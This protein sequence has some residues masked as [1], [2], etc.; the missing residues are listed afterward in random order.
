MIFFDTNVQ[1]LKFKVLKEVADLAFED[2]LADG[3]LDIP[4][5]IIPGP[6][7]TMRC[8]IYKERAV[9]AE[10]VKLAMGTGHTDDPVISV[11]PIACDEC[12]VTQISVSESC[13]G[14]IAHRCMNT[15]PRQAI[16]IKNH[17]AHIDQ[18]LC[19][20]CGKCVD[21]CPYGAIVKNLRPCERACKAGAISMDERKKA[22][23]NYDKCVSCGACV[24]QCPF[25]A[26]M[27]RS[28][29]LNAI[30]ILKESDG[31]RCY[32]V[33]AAVAPSISG[34]FG[35][36]VGQVVSGL[37]QLGFY[38][39]V[40]AAL[41][42]DMVA[43]KEAKELAEKGFLTSSCCPAFVQYI[44]KR[45]PA[46]ADKVSHNLS[47]MAELGRY[48]KHLDPECKVI[49]IGPCT[50]KKAEARLEGVREHV[51]EV[52]TF[53][54][55]QALFH[56]RGIDPAVLEDDVLDNASYYGRIFARSGGLADAVA[57][58]LKEHGITEEQFALQAISCSGIEECKVA[59][60]KANKGVLPA[61]FIEG[62][63][64]VD[65]CIGGPACLTH[66]PKDRA[67][68]DRYSREAMEKSITDAIGLL[69]WQ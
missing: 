58:A 43:F 2:R 50:A 66:G 35:A 69:D 62:M 40:E 46:M 29:I 15:C 56:S 59:L 10:R 11:L 31:G 64:C 54:E 33:Y 36:K 21:A 19:I 68:V 53:E 9:V 3:V 55:L 18:S 14:C 25:G 57:Q 5:K 1:E 47:P 52:L 51:D 67:A 12:P 16:S 23:I 37:K 49:F 44:Q 39:V 7:A 65:G 63:A 13:R 22:S 26:I 17:R 30:R 41:G 42:A 34:Q 48:L 28:F 61:N 6:D 32:K 38:S 24:Y 45:F 4:E 27:D 20:T 60:L 8:C